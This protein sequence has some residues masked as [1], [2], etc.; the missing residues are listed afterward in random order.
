MK[1]Q[2]GH[3]GFR[4]SFFNGLTLS[5]QYG[6]AN[7]CERQDYSAGMDEPSNP[8]EISSRDFE[9]AVLD[10]SDSLLSMG[11]DQVEGHVPFDMLPLVIDRVQ[12]LTPG[13][14][15]VE[16]IGWTVCD[17]VMELQPQHRADM[18][19]VLLSK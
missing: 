19:R 5:V 17:A 9:W 8:M 16:P 2:H 13:S 10:E 18:V 3:K 1:I 14:R 11:G 6:V 15:F 4:L 7:Y 12:R